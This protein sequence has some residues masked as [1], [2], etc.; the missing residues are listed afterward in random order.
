MKIFSALHTQYNDFINQVK[1]YLSK[2]LSKIDVNFGS[3]SVFGQIV[4]VV[5]SAVQNIML[6]IEDA[7][8]EQ[9]KYT[10]QRNSSLWGLATLSGYMPSFGKASVVSLK[11]NYIL[12]NAEEYNIVLDDKTVLIC[13]QNGLRYNIL[14]PQ[15]S[16]V[17]NPIKDNSIKYFSAVQGVF[18]TQEFVATGGQYYTI[19]LKFLGNMDTDYLTVKVNGDV[20]EQA[21]SLYDMTPDSKQ[22]TIKAAMNGGINIIFGNVEHGRPLYADDV[23]TVDYLIHDGETGN[24]DTNVETYF[25]FDRTMLDTDGEAHDGNNL[26]NITF[27]DT[28]AIAS[29]S[30]AE[31][32]QFMREMIGFNSRSLVL[33][34]PENYKVLINRFGFCGYNKTWVDAHSMI[35]NSLIMKNYTTNLSIGTDYFKLTEDDFKLTNLQ[36]QTVLSYIENSGSQ[37]AATKYNIIDPELCKYAMY[38]YVSLKSAKYNKESVENQIMQIV[39]AFFAMN[40]PDDKFI[41]KSDIIQA[42]KTNINGVDGVDIYIVSEANESA[43]IRGSYNDV[44]YELN[45]ATGQYIE[46]SEFVK[47]YPGENPNLGLDIHGNIYMKH[48]FQFPVL[49]GGWNCLNSDNELVLIEKPVTVIFED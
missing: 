48:D 29:G 12:N 6:Y 32:I 8:V 3:N 26:F 21:A 23:V 38:I 34:S 37:L 36:K 14:L 25:V 20:W 30:N 44:Y 31:T 39:G 5:G 40:K 41:P 7:L 18:H 43:I 4:T 17:L 16:I 27:A 10:A 46:K 24:M 35:V 13:T 45:S 9:N 15:E 33:A 11:L 49:M 1:N 19:N 2:T 42:I 47:L 22:Y 28:D